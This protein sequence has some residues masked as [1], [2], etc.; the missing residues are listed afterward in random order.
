MGQNLEAFLTEMQI[1][2]SSKLC[3]SVDSTAI[4]KPGVSVDSITIL[5]YEW[6]VS[7][8]LHRK[9]FAFMMLL[10]FSTQVLLLFVYG[11]PLFQH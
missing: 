6:T 8:G 9:W 10:Q 4:L 11:S 2:I 5:Q 3:F 1:G 7:S